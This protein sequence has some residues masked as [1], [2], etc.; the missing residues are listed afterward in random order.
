M[1]QTSPFSSGEEELS[2]GW[3]C[4][5]VPHGLVQLELS[6]SGIGW[7]WSSCHWEGMRTCHHKPRELWEHHFI[8]SCA[9]LLPL[10]VSVFSESSCSGHR[11]CLV[12]ASCLFSC[13]NV[14]ILLLCSCDRSGHGVSTCSE[15]KD[16]LRRC[17]WE[18]TF[19]VL[20]GWSSMDFQKC[21]RSWTLHIVFPK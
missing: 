14:Q 21:R 19:P 9:Q 5:W 2:L 10:E 8:S 18:S 12:W 6:P 4:P 1:S 13:W 7:R 20:R 11:K 3:D 17:C 16:A 15:M